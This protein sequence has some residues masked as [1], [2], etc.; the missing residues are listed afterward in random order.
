MAK[1]KTIFFVLNKCNTKQIFV[2][3]DGSLSDV[4]FGIVQL[5]D[6]HFND[7]LF[8]PYLSSNLPS[9]YRITHLGE[10]KTI[11]FSHHQVVIKDLKNPKHVLTT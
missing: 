4:G 7:V 6:G 11:E 1:D 2:D 3:D 5:D 10:G 9:I 8:V